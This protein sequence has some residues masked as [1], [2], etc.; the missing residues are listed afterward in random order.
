MDTIR[1]K[2]RTDFFGLFA[3]IPVSVFGLFM[4]IMIVVLLLNNLIFGSSLG[5]NF[6]SAITGLLLALLGLLSIPAIKALRK[7]PKEFVTK[8]LIVV[9]LWFIVMVA[10]VVLS[11]FF[12]RFLVLL[13]PITSLVFLVLWIAALIANIALSKGRDWVPFFVLSL[14]FPVIMWIVVS[15]I[16]VDTTR[17]TTTAGMKTCPRCAELVKSEA[18]LCKHCGTDLTK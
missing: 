8:V 9:G 3:L 17:T 13:L 1:A 11:P 15:V 16:S 12:A 18:T 7:Y 5:F 6:F 10:V 2:K 4:A 14:F